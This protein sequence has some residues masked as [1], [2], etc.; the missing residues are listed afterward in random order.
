MDD[1]IRATVEGP[2][3]RQQLF[4]LFSVLKKFQ[5]FSLKDFTELSAK[6]I[7]AFTLS[8][9]FIKEGA[10]GLLFIISCETFNRE[11]SLV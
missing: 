10:W 6:E 11:Q 7:S 5:L 9:R 4:S 8:H 3:L 2:N 1:E